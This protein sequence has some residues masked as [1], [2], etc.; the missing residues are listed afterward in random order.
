MSQVLYLSCWKRQEQIMELLQVQVQ[1]EQEEHQG[2]GQDDKYKRD[3]GSN[4]QDNGQG[5][6]DNQLQ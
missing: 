5:N 2:S 1:D 3:T 4:S 6:Q